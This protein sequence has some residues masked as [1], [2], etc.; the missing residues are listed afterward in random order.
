MSFGDLIKTRRQQLGLTLE[1]V[2]NHC[3]VGKSTVRKWET[4]MIQNM[5]RDKIAQLAEILKIELTELIGTVNATTSEEEARRAFVNSLDRLMKLRGITQ[6][7]ISQAMNLTASTVSDWCLGKSY[8]RIDRMSRLADLL[9]VTVCDLVSFADSDDRERRLV[10]AW[11]EADKNAQDFALE[12]LENHP[13][14]PRQEEP[15]KEREA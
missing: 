2:G 5:R 8:P 12:M 7:D 1:Q 3:G 10:K 15:K 14:K 4:G 13:A 11:R 6:A 9:G